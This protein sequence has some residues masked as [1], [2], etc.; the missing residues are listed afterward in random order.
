MNAVELPPVMTVA[1]V[2]KAA[3]VSK[4][5]VYAEIRRGKLDVIRLGTANRVWRVSRVAFERWLAA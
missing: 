2:A 3:R 1:E 5:T 4:A